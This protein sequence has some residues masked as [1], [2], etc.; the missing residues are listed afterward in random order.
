M[1]LTSNATGSFPK[2]FSS[3]PFDQAHEQENAYVKGSGGCIGLTENPVAFRRWMLSGPE[4]VRLQKQFED[5][6]FHDDDPENPNFFQN[7]EQGFAT[8]KTFPKQVSCLFKT[9]QKMGNP[10]LDDFPELVTLDSRNC[11]NESLTA[12]LSTLEDTGI[13][14]YQE[15]VTLNK[16]I[17]LSRKTLLLFSKDLNLRQHQKQ[18]RRS[19]CFKTM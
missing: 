6:Y 9:F 14:Q 13:Q 1:S 8:Q 10:F 11:V 16:S 18:E 5:E 19:R 3:I 7:H 17:N 2:L 15:F 4:L 12:A